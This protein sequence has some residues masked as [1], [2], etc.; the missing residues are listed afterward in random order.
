MLHDRLILSIVLLD[1]ITFAFKICFQ[2]FLSSINGI[3]PSA[4]KMPDGK[5]QFAARDYAHSHIV[6]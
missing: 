4:E 2:G 6:F 1:S 3:F 5:R